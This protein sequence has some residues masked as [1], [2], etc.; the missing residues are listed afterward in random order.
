MNFN[1]EEKLGILT[2]LIRLASADGDNHDEEYNLMHRVTEQLEIEPI[3]MEMLF[4]NQLSPVLP[5]RE[6]QRITVFYYLLMMVAADGEVSSDEIFLIKDFSLKLA[7][8]IQAVNDSLALLDL[9]PSGVIPADKIIAIFKV[10][11]N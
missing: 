8:P 9:Y 1:K 4:I 10:Y 7:L 11:H 3:E 5:K 2:N 6:A